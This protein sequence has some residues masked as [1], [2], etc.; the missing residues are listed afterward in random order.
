MRADVVGRGEGRVAGGTLEGTAE[1]QL[2]LASV[3]GAHGATP[4]MPRLMGPILRQ[5][6]RGSVGEEGELRIELD[7][8]P[9]EGGP[10]EA[11]H[12]LLRGQLVS[13]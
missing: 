10:R 7:Y 9:V 5:A 2:F 11:S 3:G 12:V 8:T 4:Y 1:S 13:E 6:T